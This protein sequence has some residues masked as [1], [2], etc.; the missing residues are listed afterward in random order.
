MLFFLRFPTDWL[1]PCIRHVA[2]GIKKRQDKSFRFR[3]FIRSSILV[4]IIEHESAVSEFAQ[5]AYLSF[6]FA[7]RVP[8]ETLQLRRAYS[9]D[10]LLSFSPQPDKALIG[11]ANADGEQFLVVKMSWRKNI[12]AGCIMRRPCFCHLGSE[13]AVGLCP[14]HSIWP[15]VRRR[16]GC[17]EPLFKKVYVGN[18]NRIL[19]TVLAKLSVP[20]AERYSSHGFRRGAAQEL[21]ERGSPW[22]VVA[23]AGIWKSPAFRGYVDMSKD[24]ETSV[25][26]LFAVDPDSESDCEQVH[27]AS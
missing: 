8:S 14:V 18:F 23:T 20:E 12:T 7:L 16:V 2:K 24:V 19:K 4:R 26:K 27:W 21:K 22:A 25:A 17:G 13:L 10:E 11:L 5:E 3:N 1:S 9:A 15:A 6:L